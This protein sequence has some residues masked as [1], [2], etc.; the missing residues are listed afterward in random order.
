VDAVAR[1]YAGRDV[2]VVGVS[3]SDVRPEAEA[4][5]KAHAVT[6]PSVFDADGSVARAF[7]VTQLPTIVVLDKQGRMTAVRDE[8]V[9]ASELRRLIDSALGG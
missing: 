7:R 8:P 6:Y 2:S 5:L 9:P 4:F 1:S 3:T